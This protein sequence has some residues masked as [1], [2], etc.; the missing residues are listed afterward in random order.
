[1]PFAG[2]QQPV[3]LSSIAKEATLTARADVAVS[4]R[5]SEA[6]A[7]Q[8]RIKKIIRGSV[9]LVNGATSGL[10]TFT[11]TDVAKAEA[12]HLGSSY[13]GPATAAAT[14]T[15]H[16]GSATSRLIINNAT[17]LNMTRVKSVLVLYNHY[18]LTEWL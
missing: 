9:T 14:N 8:A 18:Q 3:D 7:S 16:L 6:T 2:I 10:V 12:N 1:M 11:T 15:D 13:E 5:A 17:E 4:T